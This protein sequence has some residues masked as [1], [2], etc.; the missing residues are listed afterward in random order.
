MNFGDP[1]KCQYILQ[2]GSRKYTQ[3]PHSPEN[4]QNKCKHNRETVSDRIIKRGLDKEKN[5]SG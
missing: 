1:R 2:R 4:E 3:C 5:K